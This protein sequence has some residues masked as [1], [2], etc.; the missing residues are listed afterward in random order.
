M[1]K[2][3]FEKLIDF[4]TA[5]TPSIGYL[6]GY[7]LDGV[8]KQKDKFGVITPIGA[9]AVSIPPSN[10][11]DVVLLSG[12]N[13]GSSSIIMGTN[14]NIST[15][16]GSGKLELDK[17]LDVISLSTDDSEILLNPGSVS[18]SNS[19][20]LTSSNLILG[21][22]TSLKNGTDDK[23][24]KFEQN[25][26]E[27]NISFTNDTLPGVKKVGTIETGINYVAGVDNITYLHLNTQ[28]STTNPNI[29][30]SVIIGGNGLVSSSNNTVYVK[31]LET[32]GGLSKYSIDPSTLGGFD[33]LTMI[34]KGYL[35]LATASIYTY[36]DTTTASIY[37]YIDVATASIYNYIDSITSS[38]TFSSLTADN[39]LSISGSDVVLG[40]TLSQ[41]TIIAGGSQ[42]LSLGLTSSQITFLHIDAIQAEERYTA[43]G[44]GV[45]EI[46]K[47]PGGF[48]LEIYD[49]N[50]QTS[51]RLDINNNS[52]LNSINFSTISIRTI[53]INHPR[54]V[55]FQS[56]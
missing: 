2:V 53:K 42:E 54:F 7:D 6:I 36:I 18:I 14:T 11:L 44:A 49:P 29:K 37:N 16:N 51:N 33:N 15:S 20:G 26:N 13:S 50:N 1:A 25:I 27:L 52:V 12:N 10:P 45:L 47:N 19:I 34:T 4:I 48:N 55:Q 46:N 9:S 24:S 5:A 23:Y 30:N 31:N 40:G 28:G 43:P 22:N 32:Q 41:S 8:L 21:E 56:F 17:S 35:D 38:G 3:V 39:G